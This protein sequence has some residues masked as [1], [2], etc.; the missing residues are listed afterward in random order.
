M[1][2]RIGQVEREHSV[3]GG[4]GWGE[5]GMGESVRLALREM[6]R[7]LNFQCLGPRVPSLVRE[8]RSQRMDCWAKKN[9]DN[10][11]KIPNKSFCSLNFN[12]LN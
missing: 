5:P 3:C 7:M 1:E 12:F 10:N 8:L 2:S 11:K 6:V 9:Q 4:Q